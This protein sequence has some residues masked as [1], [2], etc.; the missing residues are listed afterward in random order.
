MWPL[1][2]AIATA[3]TAWQAPAHPPIDAAS[4]AATRMLAGPIVGSGSVKG[5]I[6]PT[7]VSAQ[8]QDDQPASSV[9]ANRLAGTGNPTVWAEFGQLAAETGAV[10]LGQGFPDWQPPDFVVEQAQAALSEGFHQYTRPAGHPPLV[11]VLAKRYSEH[12]GRTVDPMSEVAITVGASQALYL[13]LQAL[14]NP[15]DE[16]ILL[17]PAFDLY[18]GQVKLAGGTVVPVALGVDADAGGWRLDVPAFEAAITSGTKLIVLNSPHNPTGTAFSHA[19]MEEIAAVLRKHPDVLVISDEVYKYT[20]YD[21]D[22]SHVHFAALPG[23]YDRTVTL[24]SA[25]KT[26]SITGWQAGWCVG[27]ERLLKPI[28]LLLPFVQF[29][30]STPVQNALSRV[31]TLAD[32][33]YEGHESYYDWLRAMYRGKREVLAAGLRRAGMG[34]MEGQGGFFLMA[35]TS[36]IDVPQR[37][38]DEVTPAAPNGVTRDW[39]FCRWMAIEGGVIAIPASP[40]YSPPNKELAANYIRFAFCKGDDTLIEAAARIEKLVKG[41]NDSE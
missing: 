28:Q 22:S 23:M 2:C 15:G 30:V 5:V 41:S 29:C 24:S 33:P 20:V 36:G 34:I 6:A 8:Q 35:D 11:E 38:L 19:E 39:A 31:L 16:V 27:P 13:T 18:Y 37:Y 1:V 14:V 3:H 25:G 10:N 9:P 26:F 40:F 17:E 21:E 4:R 12:L 32:Q 7:G